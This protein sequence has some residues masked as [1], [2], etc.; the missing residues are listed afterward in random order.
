MWV[1]QRL[2]EMDETPLSQ[3]DA[4]FLGGFESDRDRQKIAGNIPYDVGVHEPGG[5]PDALQRYKDPEGGLK[6]SEWMYSNT[7]GE[8]RRVDTREWE[9][10]APHFGG[11]APTLEPP[12]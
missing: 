3:A 8:K 2:Q 7:D 10:D 12:D 5:Q 6:G 4:R 9:M 11:E 1:T